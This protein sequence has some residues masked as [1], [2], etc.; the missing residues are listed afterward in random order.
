LINSLDL[1]HFLSL[2]ENNFN[3]ASFIPSDPVSIPHRFRGK[4]EREIS[5]F[6]AATLAWGRRDIILKSCDRLLRL[7]EDSP[8]D[9]VMNASASDLKPLN[10]FVHRTFNG[11]DAVA[12]VKSLQ[13]VYRNHGGLEAIFTPLP[14]DEPDTGAH[15]TRA[16]HKFFELKHPQRTEKH[17]A[18]PSRGSAAKR[19]NMFL[20]WMVRRDENGVDFG[21]WKSISPAQLICPLDVHSG[22]VAREFGLLTRQQNNWKGAVELTSNLRKIDPEDPVRFD[23][24]LFGMGVN[25]DL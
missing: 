9:F 12:F 23:Y 24:A 6:L 16:R 13:H 14:T 15:I 18:D 5:G 2:K 17:F 3:N 20:R 25:E 22:R 1:I 7:M 19:I 4:E 10:S 11:T 21:I 8:Y